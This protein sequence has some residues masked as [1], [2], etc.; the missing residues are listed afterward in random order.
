MNKIYQGI[1]VL[2]SILLLWSSVGLAAINLSKSS[3][4]DQQGLVTH[5][6]SDGRLVIDL[7]ILQ[8][9]APKELRLSIDGVVVTRN[10]YRISYELEEDHAVYTITIKAIPTLLTGSKF[11]LSDATGE[12][13]A[14]GNLAHELAFAIDYSNNKLIISNTMTN[15]EVAITA[16]NG[17]TLTTENSTLAPAGNTTV[18]LPAAG[19]G[20]GTVA[21]ECSVN[22]EKVTYAVAATAASMLDSKLVAL[23]AVGGSTV[24]ATSGMGM[25]ICKLLRR[26]HLVTAGMSDTVKQLR[27]EIQVIQE[28][29]RAVVPLIGEA[30]DYAAIHCYGNEMNERIA[31]EV[32][33]LTKASAES[34]AQAHISLQS[35]PADMSDKTLAILDLIRVKELIKR[36]RQH[37]NTA[38]YQAAQARDLAK[39]CRHALKEKRSLLQKKQQ[40]QDKLAKQVTKLCIG[41]NELAARLKLLS[42]QQ[43][44]LPVGSPAWQA[45]ETQKE[46]LAQQQIATQLQYKE[47]VTLYDEQQTSISQTAEELTTLED[48]QYQDWQRKTELARQ[49]EE[50]S[51]ISEVGKAD[52]LSSQGNGEISLMSD[53]EKGEAKQSPNSRMSSKL[54]TQVTYE[55]PSNSGEELQNKNN[56]SIVRNGQPCQDQQL[57]EVSDMSQ[58]RK[59]SDFQQIPPG[60]VTFY[61][62]S[63]SGLWGVK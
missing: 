54:T 30:T 56:Y 21:V 17:Q 46:H 26:N 1:N 58:H 12:I 36:A 18:D 24:L 10:N 15:Q 47:S 35:L 23:A 27:R 16:I 40:A 55:E 51:A 32:V 34:K 43:Q 20:A 61:G 45:I 50:Q 7:A 59:S 48:A 37:T 41:L 13:I 60:V 31:K 9:I 53:I 33:E 49:S 63:G 5:K 11:A 38:L 62:L 14:T 2:L 22:G 52:S 28:D 3:R 8:I 44:A 57:A 19:A 39:T 6:L 25:A 4:I 29:L 42:S